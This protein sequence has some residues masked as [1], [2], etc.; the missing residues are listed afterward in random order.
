MTDQSWSVK[1]M[2]RILVAEDDLE[3]Q[4]IVKQFLMANGYEVVTADDGLKAYEAFKREPFDLCIVDVMMPNIDG[5]K[6]VQMIRNTSFVP[7]IMLT[8]LGEEQ[9]QV[10]GFEVGVDDYITKP[11]SFT[12][13]TARVEAVLRRTNHQHEKEK[14]YYVHEE[15]KLDALGYQV[16]VNDEEISLTTREFDILKLLMENEGKVLTRETIVEHVW[17]YEYLGETRMIDTHIKNLRKKLSTDR[18]MTV[19]GVGYK[20][21]VTDH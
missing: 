15:L 10:R 21:H 14:D 12:I 16:W 3:I 7:I 4:E 6:L 19:K 5:I 1:N 13:L 9:D 17:G 20:L 18:I 2:S 11:F 8:A